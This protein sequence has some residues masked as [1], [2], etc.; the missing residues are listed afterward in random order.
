MALIFLGALI[1]ITVSSFDCHQVNR[2][3]F[4]ASNEWPPV[5]QTSVHWIIRFEGNAGVLSQAAT[6][7][8]NSSLV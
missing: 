7:A 2:L 5:R 3:D 4:I 8:K 1:V 6:E